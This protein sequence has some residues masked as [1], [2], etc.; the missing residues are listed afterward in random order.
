[1]KTISYLVCFLLLAACS[2]NFIK[3]RLPPPHPSGDGIIFQF[4]APSARTVTLA[5]S[6]PDNE[7]GGTE[8]GKYNPTIDVMHDDGC[9]GDKVAGDGIWTI[10]KK[11]APGRYEYKYVIDRN[12]WR[13]DPNAIEH[14]NDTHGG[15][16][17]ILTVD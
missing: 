2:L 14:S 4:E 5:G 6:F 15:K 9:N 13:S 3:K 11:I 8:S 17:S 16:N 10:V 12:S 7:W 1:M